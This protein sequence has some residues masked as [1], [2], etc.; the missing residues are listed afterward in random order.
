MEKLNLPKLNL[1]PLHPKNVTPKEKAV[2]LFT[3]L[4]T[5]IIDSDNQDLNDETANTCALI[6]ARYIQHEL[7]YYC[8]SKMRTELR[9]ID[10]SGRDFWKD[11]NSELQNLHKTRKKK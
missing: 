10:L 2:E 4:R 6:C 11:V 9:P 7:D 1:P 8:T 3:K 5:Q